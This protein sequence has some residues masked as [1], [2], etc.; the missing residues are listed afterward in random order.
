MLHISDAT[1]IAW[2][3]YVSFQT[4]SIA[5]ILL[6]SLI[7]SLSS[8]VCRI[9]LIICINNK[10]MLRDTAHTIP[11]ILYIVLYICKSLRTTLHI[12]FTRS[13]HLKS[14]RNK[15]MLTS[16]KYITVALLSLLP[17]VFLAVKT[18]EII[19]LLTV[20]ITGE[21]IISGE[22][23]IIFIGKILSTLFTRSNVRIA[24]YYLIYERYI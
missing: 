14:T 21:W 9:L 11:E 20:S 13:W 3:S 1:S 15:S 2:L 5:I 19:I 22:K 10:C 12:Y 16:E 24:P 6:S 7:Y 17:F 18:V 23:S 8:T 4:M